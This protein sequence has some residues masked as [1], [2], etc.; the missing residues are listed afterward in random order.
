LTPCFLNAALSIL[1]AASSSSSLSLSCP[2][3]A[4]RF[5]AGF[6][7]DV[8]VVVGLLVDVVLELDLDAGSFR[9]GG[10]SIPNSADLLVSS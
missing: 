2:G 9:F 1:P 10:G 8:L 7:S 4:G 6:G 3:G 5:A